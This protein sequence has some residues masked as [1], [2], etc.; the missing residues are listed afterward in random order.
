MI[1]ALRLSAAL[2][3]T[4]LLPGPILLHQFCLRHAEALP[5]SFSID[6][7]LALAG[8]EARGFA[9][10]EGLP[11]I[12]EGQDRV[13]IPAR[14][15]F[16]PGHC[17]LRLGP[18]AR[19]FGVARV[20]RSGRMQGSGE[21]PPSGAILVSDGCQ[22]FLWRGAGG[23]AAWLRFLRERGGDPAVVSLTRAEGQVAYAIG[24]RPGQGAVAL[25]LGKRSL[26][27]LRLWLRQGADTIDVRLS[28]YREIFHGGS[29]PSEIAIDR[30]GVRLIVFDAKP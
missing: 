27:P 1:G 6:G 9:G 22:P 19:P 5:Q 2:T 26:V 23:E 7:I 18:T 11:L 29:F 24:G 8:D 30:G 25:V 10:R 28:G 4:Y 12:G 3:L 20:D 15:A 14:L 16:G 21:V 13:E 17:E